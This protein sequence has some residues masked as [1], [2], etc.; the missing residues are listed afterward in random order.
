MIYHYLKIAFRNLIKYK[1]QSIV[2][3]SRLGNW[4][5]PVLHCLPYGYVM[6]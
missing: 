4:F 1:T 5:H 3:Y 6:K 2:G